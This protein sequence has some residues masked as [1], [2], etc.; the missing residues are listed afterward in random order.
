MQ[1][2]G[3]GKTKGR[4]KKRRGEDGTDA[5]ATGRK[6]QK[7]KSWWD[8]FRAQHMPMFVGENPTVKLN[9]FKIV[10]EW[11]SG[12]WNALSKEEQEVFKVLPKKEGGQDQTARARRDRSRPPRKASGTPAATGSADQ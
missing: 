6:R 4:G 12:R 10:S 11:M 2:S 7:Q 1:A 5:T 8:I 3:V 9:Q